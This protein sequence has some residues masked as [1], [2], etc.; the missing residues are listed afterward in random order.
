MGGR[1][2]KGEGKEKKKG[3]KE[4]RK[5]GREEQWLFTMVEAEGDDGGEG[6]CG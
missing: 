6:R 3:K 5:K 4:K 2:K 1:K